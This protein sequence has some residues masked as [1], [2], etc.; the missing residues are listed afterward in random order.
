MM[1]CLDT[2]L[3]EPHL[4]INPKDAR[5]LVAAAMVA[6]PDRSY[7]LIGLSSHDGGHTWQNHDFGGGAGG[8]VWTA[9]LPDGD[10]IISFLA[11]QSSELQVFRSRDGGRTWSEKPVIV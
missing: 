2:T 5:N 11:G 7:G 10:A 1:P 6:R 4:S 9:F 3:L 8:D